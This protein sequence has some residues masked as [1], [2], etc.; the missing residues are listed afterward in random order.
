MGT[1]RT[2]RP[3]G[4]GRPGAVEAVVFD[5][6]GTLVRMVPPLPP[7]HAS[8][9]LRRGL[10]GPA[11]RWGDQWSAGPGDGEEHRAHSATQETYVAWERDRLRRRA[12]ECGVPADQAADL[13]VELDRA[14]KSLSLEAFADARPALAALRER[15]LTVALCS[16]WY[17]DLD[18]AVERTGLADLVDVVVTS[19]RA[20]ARKP[21]PLMYDTVLEE[22]GTAADRALFVG[23]M[24]TPD[25]LGPLARGMR[26]VH[27][28]RP[29]P[30]VRGAAPP[31][32][33]GAA[34][35]EGLSA[36]TDLL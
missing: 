10:P 27:L 21:H 25:V 34:R 5:F 17:W 22:C 7:T 4:P 19:A 32:P 29:D 2:G 23:D 24:W 16:N 18:R 36:L 9:F 26:A 20:G 3:A 8:V 30:A 15:G 28:H 31:L 35:I 11:A 12:L 14:T 13:A 1:V 33:D 6:Y